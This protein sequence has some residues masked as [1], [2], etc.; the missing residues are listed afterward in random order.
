MDV[1]VGDV[2]NDGDMDVYT[3]YF[4]G[5]DVPRAGRLYKNNG[6]QFTHAQFFGGAEHMFFADFD[7]DGDLDMISG[8]LFLN[9]GTGAFGADKSA[10]AGMIA[11]G[12]GGID[13][14]ADDDGDLDIIMNRDDRNT[15]Y[16]RYYT[17]ELV[18][19]NRWLR[20]KLTGPGGQAG[21]PG[22]KVWVYQEGHLGEAASLVGYREVVTANGGFVNGP[23]PVQHFGLKARNAVD[24][25]VQFVT[26]QIVTRSSVPANQTVSI[27]AP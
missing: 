26:G 13:F 16:L 21:A 24:V 23:S 5:R 1:V 12:R 9:N 17:N 8:G 18:S 22:A 27:V 7:N 2:D 4:D 19:P 15:P 10:S 3:W 25:K 11:E 14:D 20:V 6:G